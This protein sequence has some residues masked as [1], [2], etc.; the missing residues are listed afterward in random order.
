MASIIHENS[1]KITN[2][3]IIAFYQENAHLHIETLNLLL[4]E[5][6][7]SASGTL[8]VAIS[9]I[10]PDHNQANELILCQNRL[11]DAIHQLSRRIISQYI[12]AKTQYVEEFKSIHSGCPDAKS[13]FLENNARFI[14]QLSTL[15]A[16]LVRIKSASFDKIANIQKQ[17]HKIIN[18]NIESVLSNS[19]I[20]KDYLANFETNSA[21]MIQTIQQLIT[22]FLTD[23]Q[24][25]TEKTVQFIHAGDDTASQS[26]YRAFYEINDVLRQ[27]KSDNVRSYSFETLLS[28]LFST[29]SISQDN[30][31]F[32]I[33]REKRP[34]L[35]VENYEMRD[36]NISVPETK[37]FI[38]S[39]QDKSGHGI[40]ISQYTGI[41]SKP[42][43]HIEI[44]HHRVIIY[45]HQMEFS[46]EKLQMATD[47]IDA[48]SEK[49]GDFSSNYDIKYSVPK[50]ILDEINRE[51]QSFVLQKETILNTLKDNYKKTVS[52]IEDVK[53]GSLDKYLSTRYSSCKKQGFTCD[54]CNQFHVGTLKG[55]AAHKR[56]CYRKLSR[57]TTISLVV[58]AKDEHVPI[59]TPLHL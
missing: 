30:T 20:P 33:Q 39:M 35:Y 2:P 25:Q 3:D 24:A 9:A 13:M 16:P 23:K 45:L 26:Y 18:A 57:E 17:F 55:L 1:L 34:L 29:A 19:V 49:L 52:Q 5:L 48:I 11:S 32:I 7:K 54:L 43:F 27:L 41:T 21:Q 50:D 59:H 38:A 36:R 12:D 8:P 31:G 4:I 40:L 44:V 22:D 6:I 15:F 14:A 46:Q 56:G 28:Q 42:N 58:K 53:F 47:M 37:G 10:G 51:Y